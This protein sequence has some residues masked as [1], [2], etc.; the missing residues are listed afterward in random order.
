LFRWLDIRD[1]VQIEPVRHGQTLNVPQ[2]STNRAVQSLLRDPPAIIRRLPSRVRRSGAKF[3]RFKLSSS[4]SPRL[5]GAN[6]ASM[7]IRSH[8]TS[9]LQHLSTLV[10]NIPAGWFSE[11]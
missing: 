10:P 1:D 5:D 4:S 9:D 3:L 11:D 7:Q 2:T 6:A 8:F